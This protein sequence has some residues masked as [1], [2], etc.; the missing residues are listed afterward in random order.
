MTPVAQRQE[1]TRWFG[2][3]HTEVVALHPTNLAVSAGELVAIMG[4]SGSGKTTLLSLVGGLDRPRRGPGLAEGGGGRALDHGGRGVAGRE[5]VATRSRS[6]EG[7]EPAA[8]RRDRSP[9]DTDSTRPCFT[10]T[11]RSR[12][13]P[14]SLRR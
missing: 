3:G 7:V 1:A 13:W 10:S 8:S 9:G 6:W 12:K 11:P 4:P 2:H 14:A 5:P